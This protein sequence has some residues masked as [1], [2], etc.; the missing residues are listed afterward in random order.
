MESDFTGTVSCQRAELSLAFF[1]SHHWKQTLS[2]GPFF[3]DLFAC[4]FPVRRWAG[5]VLSGRTRDAVSRRAPSAPGRRRQRRWP[6]PGT[7]GPGGRSG[8]GGGAG[9][10]GTSSGLPL[11]RGGCG[12]EAAAASLPESLRAEFPG[13]C[14]LS[15]KKRNARSKLIFHPRKEML[16]PVLCKAGANSTDTGVYCPFHKAVVGKG[17]WENSPFAAARSFWSW[18]GGWGWEG[19]GER[20]GCGLGAGRDAAAEQGTGVS[21]AVPSASLRRPGCAKVPANAFPLPCKAITRLRPRF[22]CVRAGTKTPGIR[23]L[24][25][26]LLLPLT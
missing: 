17:A 15:N 18:G 9:R 24:F 23:S 1:N 19:C 11:H 14:T 20:S 21:F 5:C 13:V 25:L 8:A 26:L 10:A 2:F 3:V 7:P 12:E 16:L 6:E 4:L 22:R